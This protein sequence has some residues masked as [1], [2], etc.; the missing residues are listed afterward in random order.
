MR[1]MN[2]L[3]FRFVSICLKNIFLLFTWLMRKKPEYGLA[4]GTQAACGGVLHLISMM[5]NSFRNKSFV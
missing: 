4:F 1:L 5:Q 3:F 2:L